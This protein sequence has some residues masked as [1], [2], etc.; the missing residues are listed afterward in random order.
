MALPVFEHV[1]DLFEPSF[2]PPKVCTGLP[3]HLFVRIGSTIYRLLL[4][5]FYPKIS[6]LPTST[7]VL[8]RHY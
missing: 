4:Y 8:N 2:K 3:L 6:V 7:E 5:V 1:V